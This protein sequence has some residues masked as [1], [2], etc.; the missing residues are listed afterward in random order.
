M[1]V[2]KEYK[3]LFSVVMPV[4]NVE[5]YVAEAIDSVIHQSIGFKKNIQLIIV[6]DGSTDNSGK[7]C[8]RYRGEYPDNIVY[9][10]QTNE[11]VSAARNKGLEFFQGKYVNF[12]DSDDK[13]NSDAFEK[14]FNFFETHYEYIDVVAC[15]IKMF[16][17]RTGF[18]HPL[19]FKFDKDKVVDIFNEY[20]NVQL[21]CAT[22]FFKG[23][24]L[25]NHRFNT[26][27]KYAEDALFVCNTI[28]EREKYGVLKS[29]VYN[30]R[31]RETEDS[32]IDVSAS[33]KSLYTDTVE[34]SQKALFEKS[35]KKY[36]EVIRYIQNQVMYALQ[37]QIGLPFPPALSEDEKERYIADIKYLL[38]HIEDVV[39]CAQRYMPLE[40]KVY[41]LNLKYGRDIRKEYVFDRSICRFN[42]ANLFNLKTNTLVKVYIMKIENGVLFLEGKISEVINNNDFDKFILT[43]RQKRVDIEFYDLDSTY[44][45]TDQKFFSASGFKAAIPLDD[46]KSFKFT[47]TYK[48]RF[49]SEI[50]VIFEKFAAINSSYSYSYYCGKD[51]IVKQ[52]YNNVLIY[53]YTAQKRI[54]LELRYMQQLFQ[55]RELKVIACRVLYYMLKPFFRTPVWIVSDRTNKTDDNGMHFFEYLKSKPSKKHNCYFAVDKNSADY[56]KM[57]RIGKVLDINSYRYRLLF[58]FSDKI[59]SSQADEW[60]LNAFKG[61]RKYLKDLYKFDFIFLQHGI[62]LND[63]SRWLHKLNKNIKI[64]VT[65]A[66]GEWRSIAFGNYGYS[67]K[68]VKLT[69][70]PR[71]DTLAD[72]SENKIVFMPTWRASIAKTPKPGTTERKYDAK[73]KESGYFQFY[74]TL[75]NDKRIIKALRDNGYT[76]KFCIH[77]SFERQAVDFE[78]ND[79]VKTHINSIDYQKEFKENKLL[80]TDFSSVAFDFAYLNKPVIYTQFDADVFYEQQIYDKGY[81][82]FEDDG[83]GPVCYDY[84]SSVKEIVRF[85]ENGCPLEQ[86]YKKR[87]DEFY[88]FN[89]MNNCQRVYDEII[90]LGKAGS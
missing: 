63:L 71:Y 69:G 22:A 3:Y 9:I 64:F 23:F 80:V 18:S 87:I 41:I 15:R 24:A 33:D 30:Y 16:G 62:I 26:S 66:E 10:E 12:L 67:E 39:I 51:Y 49:T 83:F 89:D 53:K 61:K 17:K 4:Y 55:K 79:F 5:E 75:I 29:A 56:K 73:F 13:W 27:L 60:V 35:I 65:S 88:K 14:V 34:I 90:K 47:V 57:K 52:K 8:E 48:K 86:K 44:A 32:A 84:E 85:I 68:E 6:N 11:G 1:A 78:E 70:L 54:K 74:N 40:K 58:L 28:I 25:E 42:N 20:D 2:N 7:I 36:G 77:P 45:L 19:D 81:F 50:S 76:A 21:S 59:I 37:W 46:T 72:A 43:D 82:S 31:K 38:K